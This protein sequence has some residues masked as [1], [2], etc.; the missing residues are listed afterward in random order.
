MMGDVKKDIEYSSE[1]N[2]VSF[3]IIT[4]AFS[5][6]LWLPYVLWG[7]GVIRLS[8]TLASM[9]TLAVM[10]GAFGPL[11]AAVILIGRKGG[12]PGIKQY[13]RNAFSFRVKFKYY[14]I[15]LL[16]PLVLT[17][18]AHYFV[19]L[20]G[21]D[22]LPDNLLPEGIAIPAIVL[23]IPYFIFILIAG[24]GQEEF[25]WRGYAQ[26]PLQERFGILG[27]SVLLGIAWAVW[28]LPLWFM[29]GEGHAYYSFFAFMLYT[30]STSVIIGWLYNASGKKLVIPWFLHAI[31]NVAVPLFPVLHLANVAQPAYW[32]W[33]TVNILAAVIITI[34]YWKKSKLDPSFGEAK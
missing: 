20:T 29:P 4:F 1:R 3:F 26:E 32:V 10:I 27:G 7:L 21:I 14:A 5:W 34:I 2:V 24:G 28:H 31:G 11:L 25:G 30:V 19:N 17:A 6:L 33:V 16:L 15:A 13:F 23:V 12:K 22:I 9:M 18:L 8:E